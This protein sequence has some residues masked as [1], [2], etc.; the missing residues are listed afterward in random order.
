M[1]ARPSSDPARLRQLYG[2]LD[3]ALDVPVA[4]REAWLAGLGPEHTALL[5]QLRDL[6]AAA[7]VETD[8][9]MR[10]PAAA[11]VVAAAG[12][13]F[14]SG[15]ALAESAGDHAGDVIGPYRLVSELGTGGMATV[16]LAERIDGAFDREVALKLPR[17]GWSEGLLQ[18]MAYERDLLAALEHPR[19]A[20]LYDAGLTSAGRPWLAM[21]RVH[22]EPID[23]YCRAH[24]L[25]VPQILRLALQVCDALS[26][27]HARLIV[28]RDL[29]PA[30]ILVTADSDV[31][32]VDFGVGKLLQDNGQAS[33]G[34]TQAL[35]S[36]L[37]PDYASPEQVAGRP[38]TVATDV[39]S[40]GVVLFE[41]L[42]G[43]RPYKLGR[44]GA[45]ALEE[46]ILTADVGRASARAA[47]PT[48]ARALRGDLDAVLAK[49]LAKAP[50]RRYGSVDAMAADLQA[51][52]DGL[53]VRAQAPS[54]RYRATKF[55]RRNRVPVA[56]AATVSVALLAG[57]GV[58]LWQA[59]VARTQT[60][61]AERARTFVMSLLR[62]AQPRQGSGGAVLA[63]E[64]LAAAGERIESEFADDPAT[65]AELG[66]LIGDGLSDLGDP[67]LGELSLRR[68]VARG[69]RVYGT[70]HPLVVR[71]RALLI[72]SLSVQ[73][74]DEALRLAEELVPDALAGLPQ[75][76]PDA[77]FTLRSLSF[78]R[79]KRNQ[80]QPA[81]DALRQGVALAERYLGHDHQQ[82]AL[83]LGLL[84]NTY[85]RFHR[86]AEQLAT[87]TDARM[88]A[89]RSLGPQRPH[90]SLTAVE[91][92]YAEALRNN[93]RPRDAIPILRRVLADQ[94]LLDGN[95]TPRVRNAMYQLGL[96]LAEVGQLA[97]ALPLLRE[98]VALEARQNG[99]DNEDRRNFGAGLAGALGYARHAR[100]ALEL[101]DRL[102]LVRRPLPAET[103]PI[104]R[105]RYLR[106][107][108]MLAF[109]GDAAQAEDL[110]LVAARSFA[111]TYSAAHAEAL[112]IAATNARLQR[113]KAQALEFARRAWDDPGR[114]QT[115]L[116]GQAVIAAELAA[117]WLD[118]GEQARAEPLARQ[119]L[120]LF[121]KSQVD[122]SPRSAAAW[123]VH[124]RLLLRSGHATKA[125]EALEPLIASWREIDAGSPWL[126][127]ALWWSARALEAMGRHD[128][129]ARRLVAARSL[130][131]SS[132]LPYLRALAQ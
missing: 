9:F 106:Y 129:A 102:Q 113:R 17:V 79:A 86:Y 45:A 90:V 41:L 22:G 93:D 89:E 108:Q 82:A 30:N 72:E 29:K 62:Q 121:E 75:T 85:G 104:E 43:E 59:E 19:I 40:L 18:R 125:Y 63:T 98:V 20:R 6:L 128:E 96:A 97:E 13:A 54:W 3:A 73:Q 67:Q 53:P 31:R 124:A 123:V 16:W 112:I 70:R 28:H 25:E 114:M 103:T 36:A 105:T 130:L 58:S 95:E 81:Y 7:G 132:N 84:S 122:P 66:I 48:R 64:L 109:A 88:R 100:E 110:S 92:W 21:E 52:L 131:R 46:A 74:P 118:S 27:A 65:A 69:T 120:A 44:R 101:A 61:R 57:L 119:A 87:A 60:A 1:N 47:N 126:G 10:R 83:T 56:A 14:G 80:E 78:Q 39:Y 33:G 71:G 35:G 32:L 23:V 107:A 127:E 24:A 111:S 91:R 12:A 42:S 38:L 34:L 15:H 11:L 68:A 5:P 94:R 2:L 50:E 99:V 26:H 51:V 116:S 37:T 8:D 55:V 115:R 117:A 49:A 76:A 77:V 4:Q